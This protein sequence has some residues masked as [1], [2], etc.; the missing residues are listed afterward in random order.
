[1]SKRITG[2][3][4]AEPSEHGAEAMGP[5]E[6]A[7]YRRDWTTSR[8]YVRGAGKARLQPETLPQLSAA[9]EGSDP[10]PPG[11]SAAE[12]VNRGLSG[13]RADAN[14]DE[15]EDPAERN[16]EAPT[17][18]RIAARLLLAR[19]FD[20]NPAIIEAF[21][22]SSPV[23]IVEVPDAGFYTRVDHQWKNVLSMQDLRFADLA[24]LSDREKRGDYDAIRHVTNT[25]LTPKNRTA[26]DTRAFAAIQLALPMLIITPAAEGH[27]SKVLLDAATVRLSF[28]PIDGRLIERVVEIVTGSVAKD[29]VPDELVAQIGLHELLLAI[30]FDRT[31]E[32]CVSRLV[33]MV[34]TKLARRGARDL[35]LDELHGLDE[36]V[37]W[38]KSVI[39][40]I[41]AWRRGDIVWDAVD[42]GVVLDGPPGTGKTTFAKVFAAASGLPLVAATLAKWQGS[43]SAHLGDLLKAMK[44]DFDEAR[45]M[46]PAV[47]FIDELD[48]FP[49]R[50]TIT[51]AYRDY[52][53]EVVNGFIE[54]LDGIGGRQG[55][56]FI[57]ATNDVTRCD[58]A[59]VRSGRLNRIIRIGMPTPADLEKMFRVRLRG[60]LM[61]RAL[62]VIALQAVGS[63]GADVERM[64]KDAARSARHAGREMTMDDLRQAVT[65]KDDF[66]DDMLERICLHEAGHIIVA[67][68][69][70]GPADIHA[71][72]GSTG[73]AGGMV[74]S[75]AAQFTAGTLEE[76]RRTLQTLLAGKAAEE[77]G[78]GAAGGGAGGSERSDLAQ[79]TR[80]A[81]ALVGSVGHTGPHPLLYLAERF[82]TGAILD[83]PYMRAAAQKELAAAFDEAKRIL[84]ENVG[85]L[86]EVAKHLRIQRRIDGREV[87]RILA[88]HEAGG[89]RVP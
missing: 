29:S 73:N 31:P 21:R 57:G 46:A 50:A 68:L 56:I 3:R 7:V 43:G 40:D 78:L 58:P 42:A 39:V 86:L 36:A 23:V 45:A 77:V 10:I 44:K 51:H 6:L 52:V 25:M 35:S 15:D 79:A 63:S 72:I 85:A 9:A 60:Q 1:M 8:A 32:E 5:L 34:K 26:A 65:G 82:D 49:S 22:T 83:Q 76:Y 81:A 2:P 80:I 27:L 19:L 53:V 47:L 12:P 17:P 18:G 88:H 24:S 11:D 20:K 62:D 30:R 16:V 28:P 66:S 54:Q 87:G 70:N 41:A 71:V 69:H 55:V 67:V 59:I 75:S 48:S 38:A 61:D 37:T 84:G 33:S 13:L 74:A 89:R 14:R 4:S 64:V